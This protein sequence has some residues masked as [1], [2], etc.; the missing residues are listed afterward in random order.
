MNRSIAK[1]RTR[2]TERLSEIAAL[3]TAGEDERATVT[4]DQQAIGRLARIDLMQR[5]HMAKETQ[6][7]RQLERS[8]IEAALKRI[9]EDEYGWC[10]D[11]GSEIGARRLEV[12]PTAHLC[13]GCA[14]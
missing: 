7:R 2:L 6:R 9:E 4:L 13:V 14:K 11:C 10:A 1:A 3:E 8:R 12:D 5:Q